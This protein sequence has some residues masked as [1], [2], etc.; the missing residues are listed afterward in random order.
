MNAMP[1]YWSLILSYNT[2]W[3]VVRRERTTREWKPIVSAPTNGRRIKV[4]GWDFGIEGSR[5]HY[6]IAFH[7]DGNWIEAGSSGNRLGYLTHWQELS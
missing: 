2:I 1:R 7:K 6:A 3:Q 4:H 5:R